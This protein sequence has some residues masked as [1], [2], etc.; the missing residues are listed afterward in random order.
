MVLT[1]LAL[2]TAVAKMVRV[3]VW[4]GRQQHSNEVLR[5][6][7]TLYEFEYSQFTRFLATP[8]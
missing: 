7:G 6:T 5:A 2:F 8:S 4:W 3:S 1:S